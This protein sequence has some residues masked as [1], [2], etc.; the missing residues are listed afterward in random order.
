MDNFV[1]RIKHKG[2]TGSIT[3]VLV[4][5]ILILA[6]ASTIGPLVWIFITAFKPREEVFSKIPQWIPKEVTFSNFTEIFTILPVGLYYINTIIIVGGILAVQLITITLAAYAFARLKFKGRDLL[7]I[8]LLTQ[9]M[10]ANQSV[11]LP[12]Y[13]TISNLKLLNTKL[14]IMLPYFGSAYGTFL[15]RQTFKTIPKELEDA[16]TM[17]GC[18]SFRFL[19][20]IAVPLAKPTII[21][22]SVISLLYHWSEF[23]WPLIVTDTPKARP[24]TVGLGIFAMQAEGG[25]EWTLLMAFTLLVIVVPLTMFV[26][27]QR[28]IINS[29]MRTGFK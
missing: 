20:Q 14:A 4:H 12:N 19:W 13:L 23:F 1:K 25:A 7:F 3:R 28:R 16:A 11:I 8:L 9:L 26:V 24:L 10:L 17:D 2:S 22:F 29:F 6:S 18:S 21:V 27:L 15:L 5:I